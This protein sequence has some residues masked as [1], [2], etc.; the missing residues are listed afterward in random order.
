MIAVSLQLSYI[1]NFYSIN[2]SDTYIYALQ[3]NDQGT[4]IGIQVPRSF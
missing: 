4:Y 1:Y 2:M 3:P